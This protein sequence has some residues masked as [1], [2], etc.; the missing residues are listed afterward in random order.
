M[1]FYLM[2]R[3]PRLIITPNVQADCP[4]AGWR[5]VRRVEAEDWLR[6]KAALGMPLTD[7]QQDLLPL[8][9]SGR[10]ALIHRHRFGGY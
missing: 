3:G 8:S 6:A 5:R 2:S 1:F 7:L 9:E 10:A 4:E